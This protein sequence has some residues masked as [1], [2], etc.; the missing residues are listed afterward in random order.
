MLYSDHILPL[1]QALKMEINGDIYIYH[2]GRTMSSLNDLPRFSIWVKNWK[3]FI[4][5]NRETSKHH[6]ILNN[7]DY[8]IECKFGESS[9]PFG[10]SWVY[11]YARRAAGRIQWNN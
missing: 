9:E 10:V 5:E 1:D 2:S 7:F 11:M 4:S 3:E 6:L 8:L